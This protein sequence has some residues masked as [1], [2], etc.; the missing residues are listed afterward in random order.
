MS[1]SGVL[2]AEKWCPI[3][4]T[5]IRIWRLS[6]H[7]TLYRAFGRCILTLFAQTILLATVIFMSSNRAS[8]HCGKILPIAME[9][10]GNWDCVKASYYFD[11]V[12]DEFILTKTIISGLASRFWENLLLAFIGMFQLLFLHSISYVFVNLQVNNSWLAMIFVASLSLVVSTVN[13]QFNHKDFLLIC[14]IL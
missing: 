11:F 9:E 7:L 14:F 8:S 5:M 6:P 3:R 12:F 2:T 1:G 10:C 13:Y 4:K